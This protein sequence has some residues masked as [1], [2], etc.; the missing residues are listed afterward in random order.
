MPDVISICV[1]YG[2]LDLACDETVKPR[3]ST[4]KGAEKRDAVRIRYVVSRSLFTAEYEHDEDTY[5]I[6]IRNSG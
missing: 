3:R 1:A 4:R 5:G 6:A 2:K